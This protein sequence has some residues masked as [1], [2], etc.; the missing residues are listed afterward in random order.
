MRRSVSSLAATGA[1]TLAVMGGRH[2]TVVPTS[3]IAS[4]DLKTP[5]WV[6]PA[7]ST[8][9]VDA[10]APAKLT[11]K[12][13]GGTPPFAFELPV[14]QPG[15]DLDAKTGTVTVTAGPFLDLAKQALPR[16]LSGG[17]VA[18]AA[19]AADN[20]PEQQL[21]AYA[22]A[23]GREYARLTGTA[24]KGL[25]VAVPVTVVVRDAEQQSQTVRQVV[26]LD[27]PMDGVRSALRA[28][29]AAGMPAS[30][31]TTRPSGAGG[32]DDV[33]TLR[34]RIAE[35]E[36][37]NVRLEGKVEALQEALGQGR[38]GPG[39]PPEPQVN[40]RSRPPTVKSHG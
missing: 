8:F 12:P 31:P 29:A 35:L 13:A 1:G 14:E 30:Q 18:G 32:S 26:L 23:A 2:V 10:S 20:A 21:T 36:R 40:V 6:P 27:V 3:A 25:P 19:N 24:A 39:H 22:A 15:I 34:R 38:P 17:F 33:A 9:R 4:P 7:Q 11:F 16:A 5:L 37:A 28:S